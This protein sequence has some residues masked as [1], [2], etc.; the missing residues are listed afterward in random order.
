MS[1]GYA[2][3]VTAYVALVVAVLVLELLGRR[4]GSTVPTFS[5]VATTVA[6]TT[7]GRLALLAL[8]WWTGW[9]FLARSSLPPG[10]PGW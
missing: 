3:T 10:W 6:S 4:A 1:A 5:D 8:W 9:H 7:V 2:L